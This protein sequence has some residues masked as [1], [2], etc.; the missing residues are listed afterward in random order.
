MKSQQ[1]L[2]RKSV[3]PV[4]TWLALIFLGNPIAYS[5]TTDQKPVGEEEVLYEGAPSGIDPESAKDI[6][7][8]EGPV[9]STAEFAHSKKIFFERCAGCHGVLRKGATGKPLTTDITRE[10]GTEY[11][12]VFINYGSPAGMPNWGTSGEMTS[13][14]VDMM[15]RYL[16]HEPPQP[17]EW[18]MAEM[19]E[20]WKVLVPPEQ[21]PTSKMNDFNIENLFSVT[22][23]DAGKV[24]LIDGDTKEIVS[25]VDTGY[26][27]HISRT[28]ASGRYIFTIG[29]DAL[30]NQIDGW[31]HALSKL[32]SLKATKTSSQLPE[33]IGRRNMS[34]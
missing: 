29:R 25:V 31:K 8:S 17:P 26:A 33:P 30:I 12:K 5:Q 19:K 7:D 28:S 9:M 4:F 15:A 24:A 16:Q 22:L 21:R 3:I 1:F 23:R 32:P 13:E 20:T 14:E 34:L 10:R 27:V 2:T 6:V 11:L 18:G